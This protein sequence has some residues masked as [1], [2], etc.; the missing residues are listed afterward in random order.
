M[1]FDIEAANWDTAK[2]IE[3]AKIIANAIE[4]EIKIESTYNALEFGCGT[5][6]ISFNLYSK[7]K[8]I[9][10][11]DTSQGMI[12]KLKSKIDEFKINNMTACKLDINEQK[13]YLNKY[14]IIYTS[15]VLHHIIDIETTLKSLYDLL[16]EQ[17][18]LCIVDLDEEDGSFHSD[19]KD[20]NGHNG[21][22]QKDL[23]N[24]LER[25]G[26]RDASSKVIYN[27]VKMIGDKGINYSLFLMKARK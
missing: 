17:G 26:F 19:E 14:D 6:L 20:F 7:F 24:Q 21:F 10:L 11:V 8:S 12:D 23:S 9:T 13:T 16:N 22:N 3:R 2:R 1:K 25:T 15:M 4:E 5:G 27:D 18:Y